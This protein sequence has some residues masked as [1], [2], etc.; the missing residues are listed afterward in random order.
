MC[1]CA[2]LN[3]LRGNCSD[4]GSV[5]CLVGWGVKCTDC[6]SAEGCP[7]NGCPG[8]DTGLSDGGVPVVLELWGMQS[9]FSLLLL[10]G[11]LWPGVVAPDGALSMG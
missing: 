5:Y 2:E 7:L 9:T 1:T 10:P 3:Y 8:C 6:S 11:P 4:I